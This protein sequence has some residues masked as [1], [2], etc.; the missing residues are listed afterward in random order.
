MNK[1]KMAVHLRHEPGGQAVKHP[2]KDFAEGT[3][4][5]CSRPH[6]QLLKTVP[7]SLSSK[8]KLTGHR[9]WVKSIP[10]QLSSAQRPKAAIV[11]RHV[12]ANT[13]R[14]YK[15]SWSVLGGQ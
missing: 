3:P 5:G 1:T 6:R 8:E 4:K 15:P 9:V 13:R 7:L 12:T 14:R 2:D 11:R 10:R